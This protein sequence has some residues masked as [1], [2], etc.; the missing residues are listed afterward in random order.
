MPP[1]TLLALMLAT[2]AIPIAF[3][4]YKYSTAT[5]DCGIHPAYEYLHYNYYTFSI[6]M[7]PSSST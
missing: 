1:T 4:Y 7:P 2:Y 6:S 3:V 5:V